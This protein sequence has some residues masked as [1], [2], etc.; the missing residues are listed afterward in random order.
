MSSG[1]LFAFKKIKM[2]KRKEEK[3]NSRVTNGRWCVFHEHARRWMV[4][5][6]SRRSLVEGGSM[7]V[8][9][10]AFFYI[11]PWVGLGMQYT[12]RCGGAN[13]QLPLISPAGFPYTKCRP[14]REPEPTRKAPVHTTTTTAR[15]EQENLFLPQQRVIGGSCCLLTRPLRFHRKLAW[16][17]YSAWFD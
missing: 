13:A 12:A 14:L 9:E 4:R 1:F 15:Y 5:V 17:M 16:C 2:R 6:T 10:T 8:R 11:I 3:K 7:G